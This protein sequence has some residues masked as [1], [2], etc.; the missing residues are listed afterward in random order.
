MAWSLLASWGAKFLAAGGNVA[1]TGSSPH[2]TTEMGVIVGTGGRESGRLW[3]AGPVQGTGAGGVRGQ[4]TPGVQ[5]RSAFAPPA[6]WTCRPHE[7]RRL[8][9]SVSAARTA[10]A[11]GATNRGKFGRG[12]DT[13]D[14][15]KGQGT[16]PI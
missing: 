7:A 13:R 6:E 12:I 11:S 15:P 5:G 14:R 4:S 8:A 10:S 16:L 3:Q 2:W 1:R 9:G